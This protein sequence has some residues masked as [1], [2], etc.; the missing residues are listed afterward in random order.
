MLQS[1]QGIV[2]TISPPIV[3]SSHTH[4]VTAAAGRRL[5]VGTGV[6]GDF[7]LPLRHYAP[8]TLREEARGY[9]L[10]LSMDA[11]VSGGDHCVADGWWRLVPAAGACG[12]CPFAPCG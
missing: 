6:P 10:E 12:R 1:H 9:V 3:Y 5:Q 11:Q 4:A 8:E 7:P 2:H